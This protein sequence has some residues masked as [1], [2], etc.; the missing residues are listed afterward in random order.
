M[1]GAERDRIVHTVCLAGAVRDASRR[2]LGSS[3]SRRAARQTLTPVQQIW[4]SEKLIQKMRAAREQ[5][6]QARAQ[7]ERNR[8]SR[9]H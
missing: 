5:R 4:E 2:R 9:S 8:A 6:S 1:T 3:S 7:R